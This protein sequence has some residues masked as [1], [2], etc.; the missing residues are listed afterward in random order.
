VTHAS[1]AAS[2][3][4]RLTRSLSSGLHNG[5]KLRLS[6]SA[7]RVSNRFSWSD[8]N[9]AGGT[10]VSSKRVSGP[11]SGT[12]RLYF[13]FILFLLLVWLTKNPRLTWQS[14]VF[15]NLFCFLLEAP[16]HDAV[17]TSGA[18]PHGRL[19]GDSLAANTNL[20]RRDHSSGVINTIIQPLSS[21]REFKNR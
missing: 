18:M 6:S 15:E 19:S 8:R 20:N 17:T 12:N 21:S 3:A 9:G 11:N 4:A 10:G 1:A 14:R 5:P 16:S 2:L 7:L 13:A